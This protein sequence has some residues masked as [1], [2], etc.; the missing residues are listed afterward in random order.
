LRRI[1]VAEVERRQF[2]F[3]EQAFNGGANEVEVFDISHGRRYVNVK[4]VA[5]EIYIQVFFADP[6]TPRHPVF[7]RRV[8]A[9]CDSFASNV[10]EVIRVSRIDFC[11]RTQKGRPACVSVERDFFE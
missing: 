9:P 10:A 2:S 8:G 5:T 4:F 1:K 3:R 6:A 7:S 11:D